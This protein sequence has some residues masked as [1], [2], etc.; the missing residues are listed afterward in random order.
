[1]NRWIPRIIA[2]VVVAGLGILLWSRFFPSPEQVIRARLTELAN[3][4]SF[5][6]NDTPVAA[7]QNSQKIASYFTDDIEIVVDAPGFKHSLAGREEL[8]QAVMFSRSQLSSLNLQFLD[9]VVAFPPSKQ[10]AMVNLT[11]KGRVPNDR[12]ML[13]QECK[14]TLKKVGRKWLIRK[15][16]TVK[17][18]SLRVLRLDWYAAQ[19]CVRPGNHGLERG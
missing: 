6:S 4:A 8:F 10:S 14:F 17:T 9:M 1:M 2:L 18:L 7:L 11:V 5:S 15:I 13:V 19:N 3:L 12:D 16:E